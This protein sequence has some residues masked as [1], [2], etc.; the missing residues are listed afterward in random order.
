MHYYKRNIGDYAKKAGRLTMLQHGAY[1]LLIDSCYDREIFPTL[2]Q[3]I[4][5]TW[6]STEAEVDAVKF[7]L[8]KF[9]VLNSDGQYVQN[10]ILG[11][12]LH[13]HE[14][15][16]KNKRI[17]IEREAKRKANRTKREQFVNEA[18]PNHKPLT[19]N[20][21]PSTINHHSVSKDTGEKSPLSTDEIIFGYGVPL[22]TNA[23]TADKQARSFLG[24]LR[25]SHG[26]DALVNALRD[27]I[28][29]KPLQ[30]LEWLAKTL[31]PAGAKPKLNKQEALEASNR[32][33]VERL[34]KKEGLA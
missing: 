19:I 23:G 32:A 14:N 21:E 9:F 12:L 30:P 25:K 11:E 20:Q 1:T 29:A 34:L 4:E 26:D 17:A 8:T 31:P 16:D 18:P 5:W 7:I 24:G 2:E 27:C 28:R 13:Y 3:A 33:V 22:L 6:A 10:R 15:A